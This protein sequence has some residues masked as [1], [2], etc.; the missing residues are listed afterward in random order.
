[1]RMTIGIEQ[2]TD[3]RLAQGLAY[4]QRTGDEAVAEGWIKDAVRT[5]LLSSGAREKLAAAVGEVHTPS[6]RVV[7]LDLEA[8]TVNAAGSFA[9]ALGVPVDVVLAAA[10]LDGARRLTAGL[11]Q[12]AAKMA[13][14]EASR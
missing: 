5:G 3:K 1:M 4:I 8:P 11:D 13:A 2:E 12:L 10:A 6:P 14:R 7:A 9:A